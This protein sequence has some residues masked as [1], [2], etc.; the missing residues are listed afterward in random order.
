[1]FG[2]GRIAAERRLMNGTTFEVGGRV[3][4]T[5]ITLVVIAA[6]ALM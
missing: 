4:A 1:M 3:N 2:K 5:Q 6:D